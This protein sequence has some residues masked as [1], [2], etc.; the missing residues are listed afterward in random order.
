MWSNSSLCLIDN[1]R[2]PGFGEGIGTSCLLGRPSSPLTTG[3]RWGW[4]WFT[5]DQREQK[6]HGSWIYLV[7]FC[8]PRVGLHCAV[9]YHSLHTIPKPK[10]GIWLLL[11]CYFVKRMK[12][13]QIF[14]FPRMWQAKWKERETGSVQNNSEKWKILLIFSSLAFLVLC[15]LGGE[16]SLHR[17]IAW[18]R[19]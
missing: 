6:S 17:H 11:F 8:L 16:S 7:D 14:I 10:G 13:N 2:Y 5:L 15:W 1:F 19:I 3:S 9:N 12:L 18:D 4:W